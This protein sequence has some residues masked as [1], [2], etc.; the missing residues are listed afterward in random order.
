VKLNWNCKM[1]NYLNSEEGKKLPEYIKSDGK[2]N[3]L[4]LTL[5]QIAEAIEYAVRLGVSR[6]LIEYREDKSTSICAFGI[7]YIDTD[8]YPAQNPGIGTKDANSRITWKGVLAHEIIGHYEAALQNLTQDITAL[9][10]AQASIRAAR[11][12][13]ELTLVERIILLRD[14]VFRLNKEG[15]TVANVRNILNINAR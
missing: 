8:L 11:F 7:L 6:E 9:N 13:P 12:A 15:Y 1:S 3:E 10:E 5:G 2:R 14:A 4:P